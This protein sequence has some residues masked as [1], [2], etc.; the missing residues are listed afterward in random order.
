MSSPPPAADASRAPRR[1]VH[2]ADALAWLEQ[3]GA[4]EGASVVT[5]LPD[6]SEVPERGFEGWRRFFE[7]AAELILRRVPERAVSIFFQSDIKREGV[8]ID[9]GYMVMRA[10]E[11]ARAALL[12]HK[13]VCRRPPGSTTFGRAS[14]SHMLCFSRGLRPSLARATPDVLPEAG[15]MTWSKAMG[16][17]AC[18]AA[19]R[20]VLAETETRRIVD[21]FCGHGTALAVANALGLDAT[22]VDLS[23]RKCRRARALSVDLA[24]TS[25]SARAGAAK[26][27]PRE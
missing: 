3:P 16:V 4:L 17:A 5:S 27:R 24:G 14:Y 11:R 10:A 20:F 15:A 13:I 23:E 1:D 6:V 25:A 21:P 12:W 18:L 9:K 26:R 7:E 8:W 22:G 2:R 19:C